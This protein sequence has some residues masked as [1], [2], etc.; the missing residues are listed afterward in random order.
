MFKSKESNPFSLSTL[1]FFIITSLSFS[2]INCTEDK[3]SFQQFNEEVPIYGE[4]VKEISIFSQSN[5]NLM[6]VDFFLVI[7]QR[8]GDVLS[9]YNTNSKQIVAK[10]GN[11]GNGNLEFSSPHL[12]KNYSRSEVDNSPVIYIYDFDRRV[13]NKINLLGL[14]QGDSEFHSQKSIEDRNNYY[15]NF[16]Y[17]SDEYY[18]GTAEGRKK[19]TLYDRKEKSQVD[20]Q[21]TPKLSFDVES[22]WLN[23]IYRPTLTINKKRQKLALAAMLIPNLEISDLN[24]ENLISV[25]F[26]DFDSLRNSLSEYKNSGEFD[27]KHFIVDIDSNDD[28]IIGLNYNNTSTALYTY[29]SYQDLNFLQFDW[30]GN[31]L[32]KYIL[33]DNKFVESFAVDFDK[34]KVY[35]FLPHE[36]EYNLYV[37]DLN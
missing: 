18:I 29:Y 5:V 13:I 36:K 21:Y 8:L 27:S 10:Y 37:Y 24:Q 30:D 2:L 7:Q 22:T 28:Y 31:L 20:F 15:I 17:C 4:F 25:N 12:L 26:E 23:T 11:K 3:A 9:V 19:I 34:N 1:S 16:S 14:I 32:K 33:A 35:C 6:V